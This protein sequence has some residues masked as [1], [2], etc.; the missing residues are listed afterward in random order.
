MSLVTY[1]YIVLSTDHYSY[2]T[3]L[4]KRT[5]RLGQQREALKLIQAT[6]TGGLNDRGYGFAYWELLASNQFGQL[7]HYRKVMFHPP[8][9]DNSWQ[10][11]A[12]A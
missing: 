7:Y 9:P 6:H 2:A 5:Y 12:T 4:L 3:L 8:A 10:V 1:L 11:E